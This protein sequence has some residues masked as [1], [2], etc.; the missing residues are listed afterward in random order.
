MQISY[1]IP[2]YLIVAG[3]VGIIIAVINIIQVV[4]ERRVLLSGDEQTPEL[5]SAAGLCCVSCLSCILN[6]FLFFWFITGCYWILRAKAIVQYD[7]KHHKNYCH[8]VLYRF[9]Y[10][11]LLFALIFEILKCCQCCW[12][13][14]RRIKSLKNARTILTTTEP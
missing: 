13:A 11:I 1:H 10:W 8:P 9:A 2:H 6:L 3:I 5:V 14:P 4:L 12:K 7:D